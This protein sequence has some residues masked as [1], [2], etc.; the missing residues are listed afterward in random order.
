MNAP[1]ATDSMTDGFSQLAQL[2]ANLKR[3]RNRMEVALRYTDGTHTFDDLVAQI[4]SNQLFFFCTDEAFAIMERVQYPQYANLNCFLAGGKLTSLLERIDDMKLLGAQLGCKH[5]TIAG[6]HGWERVLSQRGWTHT[7][8]TM[9][10]PIEEE[11]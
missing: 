9:S 6:R 8:T 1:V 11:N 3:W 4:M 2:V 7:C 10:T 5:L